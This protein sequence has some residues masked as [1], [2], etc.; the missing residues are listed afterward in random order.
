MVGGGV[1]GGWWGLWG[2]GG[3]G[4]CVKGEV[5]GLS[6]R[7]NGVW[8]GMLGG[9]RGGEEVKRSFIVVICM[10]II[11]IQERLAT[12]VILSLWGEVG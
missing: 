12:I 8:G 11:N 1:W 3:G 7:R 10:W 9:G 2:G 5:R 4:R 6:V